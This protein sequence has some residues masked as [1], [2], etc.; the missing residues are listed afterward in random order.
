[1]Y[2]VCSAI[3][4]GSCHWENSRSSVDDDEGCLTSLGI[5]LIKLVSSGTRLQKKGAAVEV[6]EEIIIVLMAL[7][8]ITRVE[9]SSFFPGE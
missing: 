3:K 4:G 1:M 7:N 8:Q 6:V 5:K 2:A 9:L